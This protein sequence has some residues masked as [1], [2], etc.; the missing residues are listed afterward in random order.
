MQHNQTL[1]KAIY[2]LSIFFCLYLGAKDIQILPGITYERVVVHDPAQQFYIVRIDPKKAHMMI[3]LAEGKCVGSKKT[4]EIAKSNLAAVA[5]NGSYFDFMAA[6]RT[7]KL[8]IKVLDALGYSNYKTV[9]VYAL[10]IGDEWFSLSSIF[11]GIVGWDKDGKVTLFDV[12]KSAIRLKIG[13]KEYPVK[14]F[15]KPHVHDHGPTLYSSVYS[16]RTPK[17][18][19]RNIEVIIDEGRVCDVLLKSHGN[20]PIPQNGFVYAYPKNIDMRDFIHAAGDPVSV[21][22]KYESRDNPYSEQEWVGMDYIL[23]GTPLLIKDGIIIEAL[24]QRNSSFYTKPHPR[25]AIGILADGTLVLLVVA[26]SQ[27]AAIGLTIMELAEYMQQLGCVHALNLDGGGSSS[28]VIN[29]AMVNPPA[30][31]EW[32]IVKKERPISHAIVVNPRI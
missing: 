27:T 23:A 18:I 26:G 6:S 28:M 14:A 13:D 9:P 31:H 5:I 2:I 24:S 7:A 1:K 11:T 10:K 21:D 16:D 20:T 17:S 29:G 22:I 4:S 8:Y 32:S 3:T 25:T 19:R 30:G 15:N 12:G